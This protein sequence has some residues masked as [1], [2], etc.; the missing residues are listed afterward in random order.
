[1]GLV[2][3]TIPAVRLATRPHSA[4]DSVIEIFIA[5]KIVL[6]ILFSFLIVKFGFESLKL[7][8]EDINFLWG[9]IFKINDGDDADLALLI[10][11]ISQI[12]DIQRIRYTTSH[13][14]DFS[15]DLIDEYRNPKLANNL[16]LP[17]QSGS[18]III[19]KMKRKHTVK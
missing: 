16:H 17:V 19:S 12:E 10:K 8:Q 9:I 15:D 4:D 14:I 6:P 7:K 13:P 18:D 3:Q 11:H 1:M 5:F 2:S